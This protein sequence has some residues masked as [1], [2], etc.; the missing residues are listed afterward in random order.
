MLLEK[1]LIASGSKKSVPVIS[2]A[3]YA[4]GDNSYGQ[5]GDQTLSSKSSPILTS[6]P[7]GTS[8]V[9]V[10]AG[11]NHTL[12]IKSDNT[13]WAWGYN[14]YGQLGL[15]SVFSET[16][17]PVAVTTSISWSKISHGYTH[18][19]AI[20]TDGTLWAW[21]DNG[22]GELGDNTTILK[23]SPILVSG[24]ASTSWSAIAAGRQFSLAI[25]STGQLYAWG[26]GTSGQLGDSSIISKSSP[27]LVS[28]PAS[29]SWSAISTGSNHSLAITSLGILYA[30]G[31]GGSGQLGDSSIISK[32]SPVLVSGPATT[33]WASV[34]AGLSFSLAITSTGQL[35]AWGFNSSGQLGDNTLTNKSSPVLVS[36][37][38]STSWSAIAA[39][40][41]HSLAITT[42]GI[43][44]AWGANGI[45]QLGDNTT[46]FK[47]SPVLVSG[48]AT[49]SWTS[50]SAGGG[51]YPMSMAI[52]SLGLLYAWGSNRY[53]KLG[54]A[55]TTDKSSPV[56][57]SG[58]TTTSWSIIS[59][60]KDAPFGYCLCGA[61]NTSSKLYLWGINYLDQYSDVTSPIQVGNSSWSIVNT[62]SN[63][64]LAIDISG[65]LWAWGVNDIGQLGDNSQVSKGSPVL[66]SGPATT[67]WASVSAGVSH[68]LAI[69]SL[70]RLYSWGLGVSGELGH[71]AISSRST[72]VLVS[73]PVSTSWASVSAGS[74]FSLAITSLG[75]LYAWGG[76][77]VGQLGDNTLTNK[78]SPVLVSGPATTSWSTI[79]SG[80]THSLAITSLGILY[81]WGSNTY[82]QLGD[83]TLVSKSSPVLV[84][85]PATTSWASV[86]VGL[87]FS[88]AITSTNLLYAWGLGTTGQLGDNTLVS[89]SSP[90]LVS[91]PSAASWSIVS[92]GS[93]FSLAIPI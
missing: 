90:V 19:L 91:G 13:L 8:W 60:S 73:G 20:K 34:S 32:S 62:K 93:A 16:S 18:T 82:G 75:I 7:S 5:L 72:P 6:A 70:G 17:S 71:N 92:A 23:Y 54:I 77:S 74:S 88:L 61:L 69:T 21:G 65:R 42:L 68:S 58:P 76:N 53:G 24:P 39:G 36:G 40:S 12:A 47:S 78:S 15:G 41:T 50:V 79:A 83:N 38:A 25:T 85:G 1:L 55:S 46:T 57:V 81:A 63:H 45:G 44:Y 67:S 51:S 37:P 80:I 84:S 3:L 22:S 33:S 29:T 52:S 87:S 9:A 43:L 59:L 2:K 30:W 10:T 56:L 86:S 27:I 14:F 49:T 26:L 4:W 48:P 66:V 89:K 31:L 28:G 35:Y 64:T 11:V